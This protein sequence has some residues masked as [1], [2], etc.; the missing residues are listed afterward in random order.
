MLLSI[1]FYDSFS[2]KNSDNHLF[3]SYLYL[4][5]DLVQINCSVIYMMHF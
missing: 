1:L 5:I 4:N 2:Y 3:S